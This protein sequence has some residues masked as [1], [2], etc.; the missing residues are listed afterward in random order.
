MQ[1]C[2]KELNEADLNEKEKLLRKLREDLRNE[3]MK[4]V[5]LKKLRQSQMKENIAILPTPHQQSSNKTTN[6]GKLPPPQQVP[7]PLI[8]GN[9]AHKSTS[10]PPLLRGVR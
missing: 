5:L 7:P 8:R 3:E 9:S 10:V 6:T 2:S 4:L 1:N